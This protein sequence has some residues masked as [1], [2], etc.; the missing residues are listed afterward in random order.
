M[1]AKIGISD[2]SPDILSTLFSLPF[3][4]ELIEKHFTI[5]NN[6]P[7]RDNK[8]AILPK[9]LK[10]L[11][12]NVLRFQKMQIINKKL[13]KEEVEVRKVYSEDGQNLKI[14][15]INT[16]IQRG[17]FGSGKYYGYNNFKVIGLVRI[18]TNKKIEGVG[19]EFSW[20]LFTKFIED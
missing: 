4:V 11:S 2:H 9:Q 12:D 8:F 5:D 15:S 16:I 1:K 10:L 17:T 20:S 13:T 18:K 19:G 6:L 3:G 14:T 7:G